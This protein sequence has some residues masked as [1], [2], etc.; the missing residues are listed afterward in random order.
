MCFKVLLGASKFCVV[1]YAQAF[2]KVLFEDKMCSG[3]PKI[4]ILQFVNSNSFVSN[5]S[6]L[7]INAFLK[8]TIIRILNTGGKKM[9]KILLD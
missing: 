5:V 1:E 2:P 3:I 4:G 9:I 8:F 6:S 7:A